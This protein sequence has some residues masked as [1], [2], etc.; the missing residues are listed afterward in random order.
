M[1]DMSWSEATAAMP[2]RELASANFGLRAKCL[3]SE[4]VA[5]MLQA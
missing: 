2:A 1:D 5:A 4:G 3:A